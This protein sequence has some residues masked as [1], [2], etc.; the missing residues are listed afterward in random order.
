MSTTYFVAI[1]TFKCPACGNL[2]KRTGAIEAENDSFEALRT[3]IDA[4]ALRSRCCGAAVAPETE[5]EI[6]VQTKGSGHPVSRR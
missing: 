2:D 5:L 4:Q 6:Q 1:L 3:A